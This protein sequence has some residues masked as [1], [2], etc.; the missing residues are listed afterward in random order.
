MTKPHGFY[1]SK[2]WRAF[3]ATV[4]GE[5]KVCQAPGCTAKPTHLDHIQ[6]IAKGGAKLDRANVQ[7]LCTSCHSRKTAKVDGGM[8]N[9]PSTQAMQWPG[10]DATGWPLDPHHLWNRSTRS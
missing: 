9:A 2:D 3:R 8:G 4:M 6:S 10:C 1:Q 7:A 5:R